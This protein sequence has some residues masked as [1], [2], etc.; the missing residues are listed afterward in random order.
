MTGFKIGD[1]GQRYE[2]RYKN[3]NGIEKVMGWVET[4][5][6]VDDFFKCINLHP[7][8]HSPRVIDRQK[9]VG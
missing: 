6:G 1:K 8:F 5:K 7:A 3:K 2:M 9:Q 4:Q